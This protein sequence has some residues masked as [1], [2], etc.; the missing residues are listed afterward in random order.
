[1]AATTE[2]LSFDDA[3]T[4]AYHHTG[5]LTDGPSREWLL[6]L[7]EQ[8]PPQYRSVQW[9]SQHGEDITVPRTRTTA[10]AQPDYH[11]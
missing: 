1:M 8:A 7:A 2:T 4:W 9:R 5:H 6:R 10:G 11:S 3:V